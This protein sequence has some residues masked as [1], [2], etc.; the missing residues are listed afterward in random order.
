MVGG[1]NAYQYVSS[2]PVVKFDANGKW[3]TDMHFTA[4]YMTGRIAGA[5]H[6]QALIAA[7]ASQSLD[8]S[9]MTSAPDL[10][11]EGLANNPYRIP[12]FQP[13]LIQEGNNRHSLGLTM[14][15]SQVVADE[16]VKRKDVLLFGLG[17]HTVGDFFPH[18]NLSGNP[19]AGHQVGTNEDGSESHFLLHDA[20]YTNKNPTKARYTIQVFLKKW[21]QFLNKTTKTEL[22]SDQLADVD[23][24][25]RAERTSEEKTKAF[26]EALRSI[27]ATDKELVDVTRFS[28]REE[29]V[30]AMQRAESSP[31]GRASV[32]LAEKLWRNLKDNDNFFSFEETVI[33]RE[34]PLPP[35]PK[36]QEWHPLQDF[37]RWMESGVRQIYGI[38]Y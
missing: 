18:A 2:N 19:T 31:R 10:K 1:V 24:F 6:A 9:E 33:P 20:D 13:S 15:E 35:Q 12:S 26:T 28:T 27:G 11:I 5:T 16:G 3:E 34:Y 14:P 17:M 23:R 21:D 29:R 25:I 37:S 22:S 8:D 7:I 4:V 36:P 32:E 38:P 30:S